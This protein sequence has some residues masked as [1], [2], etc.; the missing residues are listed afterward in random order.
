MYIHNFA[1]SLCGAGLFGTD[2][3]MLGS[4]KSVCVCAP[5]IAVEKNA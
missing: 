5:V 1:C 2:L 4:Q 3:G